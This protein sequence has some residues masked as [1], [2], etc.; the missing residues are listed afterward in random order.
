MILYKTR[1][2]LFVFLRSNLTGSE[3]FISL[4]DFFFFFK[5]FT[6]F[7]GRK[8]KLPSVSQNQWW[9]HFHVLS[10]QWQSTKKKKKRKNNKALSCSLFHVSFHWILCYV[11]VHFSVFWC[12]CQIFS[13]NESFDALL[14]YYRTR[15]KSCSQLLRNLQKSNTETKPSILIIFFRFTNKSVNCTDAKTNA[16]TASLPLLLGHCAASSFW[17]SWC[18]QLQ[19]QSHAFYHRPL[20]AVSPSSLDLTHP[21]WLPLDCA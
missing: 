18:E 19:L 20:S 21:V 10:N 7:H 9:K 16:A 4:L 15:E 6:H 5:S 12:S 8:V 17:T 11:G 14:D 3:N 1:S 2:T 13:L